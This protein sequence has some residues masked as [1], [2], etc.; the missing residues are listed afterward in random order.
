MP[1]P[2]PSAEEFADI[3]ERFLE[4]ARL[5]AAGRELEVVGV[6][7]TIAFVTQE[8]LLMTG[9][10]ARPLD[11]RARALFDRLATTTTTTIDEFMKDPGVVL[12]PWGRTG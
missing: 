10:L 6:F 7:G 8:G 9:I 5:A 3:A 4:L 1:I 11:E 2:V 12:R